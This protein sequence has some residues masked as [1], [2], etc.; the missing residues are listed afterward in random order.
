VL[1]VVPLSLLAATLFALAAAL[2]QR[3]AHRT[4]RE[5]WAGGDDA[6]RSPVQSRVESWLPVLGFLDRLLR[7]RL[8]LLG[9]VTNLAGFL[10]QAAALHFGSLAVVQPLL[11][12]QLLVA[13]PLSV[14]STRCGL[15]RRDWIG[16]AAICGGLVILL[17]VRGVVPPAAREN[18]SHVLLG[19]A[20]AAVLVALLVAAARRYH[21][22]PQF[23]AALES[24]AAGICF[25]MTAVFIKL[26][27]D[28]LIH[29]GVPA[30]AVDWPGYALAGSTLLGLLLE[31]DAFAA[32]S[33][34][35]AV[36]AMTI[37]NPIASYLIGVLAFEVDAPDEPGE[38]A[39]LAS[40]GLLIVVGVIILSASPTVR[41]QLAGEA[42]VSV[43]CDEPE[44]AADSAPQAMA[45]SSPRAEDQPNRRAKLR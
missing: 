22:R 6:S 41:G 35:T 28:D 11:V 27:A 36:A 16:A 19:T 24:V 30:T 18:R 29:R 15:L 44:Q 13:L 17:A 5:W 26:T 40:A 10:A 25:A 3:A 21:D 14:A 2:Q 45:E 1:L 9:W 34:A 38:L 12:A 32:G 39:G 37:T 4:A 23:R 31:Q 43:P 7:H 33:L 20:A 42:G 8:W